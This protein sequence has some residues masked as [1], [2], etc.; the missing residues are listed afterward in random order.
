MIR[1]RPLILLAFSLLAPQLAHALTPTSAELAEARRWATTKLANAEPFFSFMYGGRPSR[2]LLATWVRKQ[3]ARKL[4]DQRQEHTLTYADSQTGLVVRCVAV[5]FSDFPAVEWTLSFE[6]TG[7]KDTPILEAI[8]AL[9]AAIPLSK[10]D[11]PALDWAKGGVSSFD[12]FAPQETALKPD[13]KLHLQPGGGRS[14][15][16]VLPFFNVARAGGGV[17][18]AV[19]WSGEWAADFTRDAQAVTVK[20]GMARTHLTLH[21][22]ESIRTPRILRLNYEGDRWRGQNLLRRFILTH[23]RPRCNCQPLVAP[24]TWGTW[25][26]TPADVHLDTIQKIIEHKLPIDYYWIDA[27]WY[28][29]S[30]MGTK[31]NWA[32]EVGNWAFKTDLYPAGLKPLSETLRRA[33]RQLM[34]WFEP[35]RVRRGTPWHQTHR[36]WLLDAGKPDNE[37]CLL[38]L[39]IPAARKLVTDFIAAKVEEFGLGCYRQDFNMAP[40]PYWEAAD[41]PD[42]QGMTEIRYIEGLYA[43]WD[44]LLARHPHLIIDNC[45]S[46]GRRID[47]ETTGRSTPFWRTDGP[48]DPVAHQCHSYGLMAWVPLS[49]ISE[50]RE[51]NTY[52]FRSSMSSALCVNW[53]H[54]GDGPMKRLPADFPFAWAKKTLDEYLTI[55]K[56]YY[57]DYYPLTPYT[58]DRGAWMAW[59]LNCPEQGEG[60]VQAFRREQSI[61]ELGRPKL[62]GLE[63]AAVYRIKNLDAAGVQEMTGQT[64]MESG[65]PISIAQQPGAAVVTYKKKGD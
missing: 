7:A 59:Q 34:L 19:G 16:S 5:A 1:T 33:N 42:R 31:G 58:Q 62:R 55:R 11:T 25:G 24:I 39:G 2:E 28:G 14:S 30:G 32:A 64:L 46:G 40:L 17:V 57:G 44:E 21:P 6:N 50:D 12:D 36:Q 38:N 61:C 10:N 23:H 48:R 8:Q 26:G 29:V 35:E 60:M 47:L 3:T 22:G 18:F 49:A 56:Y 37:T 13:V 52:E 41:A 51:G 9:D 65:L 15:N 54:S 45:A 43:F 20:A 4:D 27:G 63:P 53:N